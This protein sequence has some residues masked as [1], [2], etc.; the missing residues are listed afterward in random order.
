MAVAGT[1][2]ARYQQHSELSKFS[3]K[4]SENFVQ[5]FLQPD[6][7][8]KRRNA[9]MVTMAAIDYTAVTRNMNASRSRI[10]CHF[11]RLARLNSLHAVLVEHY[12]LD[13]AG[14]TNLEHTQRANLR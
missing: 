1:Q 4:F 2:G 10:F 11:E 9:L 3:I 6:T 5:N 14:S 12:A 8:Q 13:I 7:F